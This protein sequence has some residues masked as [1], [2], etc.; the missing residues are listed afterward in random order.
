MRALCITFLFL[1]I[2][3]LGCL[4]NFTINQQ[5]TNTEVLRIHIRANSNN[6]QDQQVKYKV[7]DVVVEFLTPKLVDCTTKEKAEEKIKSLFL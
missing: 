5:S 4:G 7:K 6:Q 1:A 2:I 3:G